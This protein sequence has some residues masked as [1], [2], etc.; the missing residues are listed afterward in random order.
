[1]SAPVF[2]VDAVNLQ[3]VQ[4]NDE[5]VLTGPEGRHAVSVLRINIGEV[6]ELVDGNGLRV[7]GAVAGI[8]G[9]DTLRVQVGEMTVEPAAALHVTVVQALPKGDHGELAVD[10]LTQV[11]VDTIVPWA[12]MR[13]V[14]RWA[15]D[16]LDKAYAKW[17]SA[18]SAAAKQS[19]R[20]RWPILGELAATATVEKMIYQLVAESG[21]AI[22]LHEAAS[23][24]VLDVPITGIDGASNVIL[25]VGPEGGISDAE[26]AAFRAAGAVEAR[27]GP[28]VLRSSAAGAVAV[29][30]LSAARSWGGPVVGGSST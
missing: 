11:G 7:N 15:P 12:A 17:R 24:P 23:T 22:V 28:G 10:L 14:T 4:V 25:I 2:L 27:L 18:L 5:V 26:R 6:I 30:V 13:S 3:G 29:A 20:A 16:R 8:S 19:R 21:T 9:G 1:M